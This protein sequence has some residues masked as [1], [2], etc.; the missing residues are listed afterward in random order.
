[1]WVGEITTK[2]PADGR[3]T[4][5]R[6]YGHTQREALDALEELKAKLAYGEKAGDQTVEAFLDRWMASRIRPHRRKKTISSY[7]DTIRLY[8]KP[9]IGRFKLAD[10]R[11]A[12]LVVMFDSL[13]A[14]GGEGGKPT[15]AYVQRQ[16]YA[17]LR[18]ALNWVTDEMEELASSPLDKVKQPALPKNE[19]PTWSFEQALKFLKTVE[20]DRYRLYYELSIGA[21]M[22]QSEILGLHWPEVDLKNGLID[23]KWQ[24]EEVKGV[25]SDERIPPKSKKSR[26]VPITPRIELALGFQLER[27]RKMGFRPPGLASA[28]EDLKPTVR[29]MPTKND[30][31]VTKGALFKAYDKLVRSLDLPRIRLHDM[32]HTCA[33]LLLKSGANL[34]TVSTQLGHASMT[35]TGDLYTHVDVESQQEATDRMSERLDGGGKK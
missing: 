31:Y 35:I 8:I 13:A 29:V 30:W 27:L 10:L 21:G 19:R 12:D 2:N 4:T 22:R 5:H 24:V 32:R 25:I 26:V 28:T 3:K 34:K 20:A 17:V 6:V 18:S 15:S 16:A 9:Y 1:M 23:V 14:R 11:K 7:E 33:T